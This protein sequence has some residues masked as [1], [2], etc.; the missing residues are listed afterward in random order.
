MAA[1]EPVSHA[2]VARLAHRALRLRESGI[3]SEHGLRQLAQ[4]R[5]PEDAGGDVGAP[6]GTHPLSLI[7]RR[8]FNATSGELPGPT[9]PKLVDRLMTYQSLDDIWRRWDEATTANLEAHAPE[10]QLRALRES[11]DR[12]RKTAEDG[13]ARMQETGDFDI[14]PVFGHNRR[15]LGAAN[16]LYDFGRQ[17]FLEG[18]IDWDT[19]VIKVALVD[20]ADYTVNLATHQ[21]FSSV[22]AVAAAI[23]ETSAALANKTVTAGVADADD[24]VFTAAAGDPCEALVFYQSSAVTGGADVAAGSQRV[25]GYM[26]TA[27]GLPVTLNGGNVNVTFDS[28]SNRIF[29]L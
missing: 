5:H 3:D 20:S 23:E 6:D 25:I 21:F 24:I 7:A 19:A 18:T 26:D 12:D 16:S 14:H 9:D 1:T 4:Q 11:Q 28:G 2:D 8:L 10:A 27:T 13:W 29:K 15:T 17:G 22:N